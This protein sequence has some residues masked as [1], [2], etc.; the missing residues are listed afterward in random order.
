MAIVG[1]RHKGLERLFE[2]DDRRGVP[3]E[4]MGKL[5]RLLHALD[6]ARDVSEMGYFPGWRLHQLKGDLAGMWSVT[7]TGN[8]RLV[9]RFEDGHA[10]DVDLVDY[11]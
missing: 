9:F 6:T 1:F 8:R 11:H 4:L 10:F 2:S 5:R 3:G 7:G